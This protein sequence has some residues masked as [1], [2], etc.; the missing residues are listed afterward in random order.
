MI[1]FPCQVCEKP[2]A[3]NHNAICCDVWDCW[4]HIHSN[5][6]CKQTYRHLQKDPSP[7]YYK[8]CPKKEIPFSN[9]NDSAFEA[10]FPSGLSI[11]PKKKLHEPAI[12]EKIN[13]FTE[14]EE[15]NCK[16]H[17]ID[18][19]NKINIAKHSKKL[20]LMDLN[21]SS[22]PY[23]FDELSELLN[24]LT[25]KFQI[26]GITESRLRSE[27]FPL[28]DIN[29]PNY[30]TEHMPTKANT[31]ASLLYISNELNYKVRNNLYIHK[32]KKLESIF[33]EVKSKSQKNV[34]VGCIYK[35]PNLLITEFNACY[36]KP[37]LGKLSYE[38]KDII[39]MGHFNIDLLHHETHNQ[40][41]NCLDKMFYA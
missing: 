33:T 11:L 17:T 23:D 19:L 35:Q 41:K 36:L 25:I 3:T 29:L 10:A 14:N 20:S 34:T 24:D 16:Y 30:E 22:L 8:S 6:I 31:G 12:F 40:S 39:L 15:T 32:N 21:I 7:L 5:D 9:L 38:N 2:V 1:K 26:V 28:S 27:K 4:V 13:V 37:L 18:Q